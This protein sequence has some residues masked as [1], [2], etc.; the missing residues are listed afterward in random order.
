MEGMAD[1]L[2]LAVFGMYVLEPKIFDYLEESINR[3]IRDKGEFQLTGCLDQLRQD[4]GMIGYL[5]KGQDFDTGLPD[6]YRQTLFDFRNVG[7]TNS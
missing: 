4:E 3:N 2:F 1:D 5:V 7:N 6:T